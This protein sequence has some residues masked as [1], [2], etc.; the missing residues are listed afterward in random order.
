[1]RA[2]ASDACIRR[3]PLSR[4]EYDRAVE[5]VAFEPEAKLE[6][7]DGDLH[8]MTP[9]GSRHAV[10]MNVVADRLRRVFDIGFHV[11]VQNPLALD[12]YSEP[13]PDLAVV[14]GA[15]RDYRDA[16]P[17]SAVLVVE[18][19]NESLRHDRMVKQRLYARSGIPEYW[20]LALPETVSRSIAT[21][22]KTTTRA[23]P[24][25][26]PATKSPRSPAP[27]HVSPSTICFPDSEERRAIAR[28]ASG[29]RVPLRAASD[30]PLATWASHIR[31]AGRSGACDL[32]RSMWI[33]R[34][35][36]PRPRALA[37][38]IR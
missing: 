7:V 20:I 31:G 3:Y 2:T 18:V 9:E 15:M 36:G 11:R 29:G 16:H 23:S 24:T 1:M 17:T 4:A 5:G 30:G 14:K 13:E 6:L 22:P 34:R 26:R 25:M 19:S 10:G 38:P 12:D 21:A 32:S 33:G 35:A 37:A 27:T 8:A 28:R